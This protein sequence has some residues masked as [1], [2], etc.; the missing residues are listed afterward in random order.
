MNN[1]IIRNEEEH[2][3]RA[4]EE[5][6]REAF[7][8][9]YVP[10]CNEHYL[11]HCI[12]K[13]PDFIADL[14]FVAELDAKV[15]GSIFFTKSFVVDET[16]KHH[17]M[18]TLGPVSVIPQMHGQGI[19]SALIEHAKNAAREKGYRAIFLYGY[20]SY[21]AQHGFR[22]AK[23]FDISNSDGAYPFAHQVIELF[24]NALSDITG[25]AFESNDFHV[26]EEAAAK[27]DASFAPKEKLVTPSQKAFEKVAMTFM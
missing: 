25:K 19:G 27:Y 20:P 3:Y 7:W 21:Y 18:I 2:D 26:D 11:V 5:A 9:L 23:E 1:V 15:V 10:G 6:T 17:E 8:N 22:H 13:S 24:E 4:V 12:R 14:A 16:G